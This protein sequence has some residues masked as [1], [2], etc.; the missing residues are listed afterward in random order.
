MDFFLFFLIA[1]P[2][3]FIVR[4]KTQITE[5]GNEVLFECQANGFPKPTLFWSIEGNRTLLM[6]GI[7]S[8]RLD[9]TE[10]SEGRSILS[11]SRVERL[12]SG[13]VIVCSAVNSVGSI[14]S[15]V[16]LQL[17]TQDEQP[18]PIIVYGPVNQ[19]L[20]IKSMCSLPC[21]SIGTPVPVISWY[22]DGLPIVPNDRINISDESGTLTIGDLKRIEDTGHYTCVATST[23]GKSSSSAE[24]KVEVPT[25]PNIKF[26]RAPE[27]STF[28]G[29]PGEL[30]TAIEY[31]I[32]TLRTPQTK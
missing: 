26:F 11:I 29:Q 32:T 4:P 3:K 12:D 21:K 1:A 27:S 10:T 31:K 22:K 13:K 9:V 28:P 24:L 25:N 15:R 6:D 16:V 19:T 23:A 8:E 30:L 7:K 18:P 20:P 5:L 14:S 17:N 2:P